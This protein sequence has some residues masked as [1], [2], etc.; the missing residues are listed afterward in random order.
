VVKNNWNWSRSNLFNFLPFFH[1]GA[2]VSYPLTEKLSLT[3]AVY[4]GWNQASDLN[5][6][7]TLTLQ[8]SY[9]GS[10]WLGN[11]LYVGGPERPLGDDS[12]QPW[13]NTFD[14][15]GQFD[16]LPW[17]S[18]ALHA[19]AGWESSNFGDHSWLAGALYTR[20][21][22]ADWLYF[23]AREDGIMENIPKD[24]LGSWILLGGSDYVLSTT[25]TAELRP[26]GDGFSFRLE[27]R[28]D[29]SGENVPLYFRSG[30]NADGLQNASA[31]QDTFT[32]GLTGW[33]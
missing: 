29:N 19:D 27:Y 26:V 20:F 18:L 25:L 1:V 17:W 5:R 16:V 31:T 33:F 4:N 11:L 10:K 2:R 21:K 6:G 12:G 22:V 23:A 9:V 3:A 30:F 24:N 7:K 8:A 13:R 32:L 15:V 14:A 28:H